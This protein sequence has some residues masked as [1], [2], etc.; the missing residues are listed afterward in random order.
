M[1]FIKRVEYTSFKIISLIKEGNFTFNAI[2]TSRAT[3]KNDIIPYIMSR[4]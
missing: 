3:D 4:E 1:D 2:F